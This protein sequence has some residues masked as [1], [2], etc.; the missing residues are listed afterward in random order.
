MD[1]VTIR[2][3]GRELSCRADTTIAAALWENG[4]RVLS[5]SPKYGRP[6]GVTCA[7]GHC[8][9]CL[10]RV[11]GVPNVR[12]C[13]SR[14]RE[15]MDIRLQD[16][17]AFYGPVLQKTLAAADRLFPVGFYYKWFTRPPFVSRM[18]LRSIRPLTGVGRIPDLTAAAGTPPPGDLGARARI[19]I[20][21]GPSGLEAAA[22]Q[23]GPVLV[24]DDQEKPGGQRGLA[25]DRVAAEDLTGEFPVLAAAHTRLERARAVFAACR[26]AEFMGGVKALSGYRPDGLLLRRGQ[27]LLTVRAG[28]IVWAAGCWDRV[29]L[30][31]GNDVPG[32]LGPR[33]LYRLLVR[34]GLRV[35]GRRVLIIGGG[36]D[37][38]LSAALAAACGARPTLI[39]DSEGDHGEIAAAVT[40]KWPLHTGLVLSSLKPAP[41]GAVAAVFVPAGASDRPGSHLDMEADLVVV[42][43]PGKP[44]HDIPMQL[45]CPTVLT[46]PDGE[47]LPEGAAGGQRRLTLDGG[48]V[49]EFRGEA[50]GVVP[51]RAQEPEQESTP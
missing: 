50:A 11:D 43:I 16:T 17:G 25:L 30:F 51:G 3:E 5:H 23:G 33:A 13:E 27:Q 6:R 26:D 14:V 44:A 31:P 38:W 12:T 8:T 10:M 46:G 1:Q 9:A 37:F 35:T 32:L 48:A 29:G 21:A 2:F 47:L 20:G 40:R 39:L 7:R 45:G 15:G 24:L 41:S 4:V 19:V 42:C 28:E 18:F 36:L 49:L 22:A 34:D